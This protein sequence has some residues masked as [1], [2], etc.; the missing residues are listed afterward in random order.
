MVIDE[1]PSDTPELHSPLHRS[2]P[3]RPTVICGPP[4]RPGG[5]PDDSDSRKPSPVKN[6][7]HAD[8]VLVDLVS[9]SDCTPDLEDIL[10]NNST[11]A[12][13]GRSTCL[14]TTRRNDSEV[15]VISL[16]HSPQIHHNIHNHY[17]NHQNLR[18]Q[19]HQ[20]L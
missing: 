9:D 15:E 5:E 17:H 11:N 8:D 4:P 14:K 1:L 2:T 12:T 3:L 18:Q 20:Q 13:G 10:A 19:Q 16:D 6:V 7:G